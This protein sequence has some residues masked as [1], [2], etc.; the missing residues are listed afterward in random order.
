VTSE[1]H[2]WTLVNTLA[3]LGDA[4]G[5][6]EAL[7]AQDSVRRAIRRGAKITPCDQLTK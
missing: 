1:C 2:G 5:A 7:H 3:L 4:R 6:C